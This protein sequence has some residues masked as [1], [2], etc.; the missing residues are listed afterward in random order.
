MGK[1]AAHQAQKAARS[2]A[3]EDAPP[4]AD[5][6]TITQI[7]NLSSSFL[8]PGDTVYAQRYNLPCAE[9]GYD[10]SFHTKAW[11]DARFAASEGPK[12]TFEEY[13]V[14]K[15]KE[16][17]QEQEKE[18]DLEDAEGAVRA[19][20]PFAVA[21]GRLMYPTVPQKRICCD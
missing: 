1:N 19:M 20:C 4:G 8:A 18:R 6:G 17:A 15:E 2:G 3:G 16:D 21:Y 5:A 9:D 10:A 14:R 13:R 7:A 12:E 11:M